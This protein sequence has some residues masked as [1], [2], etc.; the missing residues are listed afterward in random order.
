MFFFVLLL[1]GNTECREKVADVVFLLDSS[2]SIW[3]HQFDAQ[4]SFLRDLI[5]SF[6]IGPNNIRVGVV[7]YSTDVRLDVA[8]NE[9]MRKQ[10]LQHAIGQI[11]YMEGGTR[12]SD[13]IR[14]AHTEMFTVTF[15]RFDWFVRCV[16]CLMRLYLCFH[17]EKIG[18]R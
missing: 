3:Q 2:F 18:K 17:A 6:T 9:H 14:F 5:D 7:T 8:L 4:L 15:V 12:T 10:D 16:V 13:A 1:T 11:Q